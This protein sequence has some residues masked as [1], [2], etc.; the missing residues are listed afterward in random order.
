MVLH[1]Q[2]YKIA[3]MYFSVIWHNRL[4]VLVR[5][6]PVR[7]RA[8][9][10]AALG[11]VLCSYWECYL[12][13]HVLE[14]HKKFSWSSMAQ[15]L[16]ED[17]FYLRRPQRTCC[18]FC[19]GA[20]RVVGALNYGECQQELSAVLKSIGQPLP[21][22]EWLWFLPIQ[23]WDNKLQSAAPFTHTTQGSTL[24]ADN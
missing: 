11:A 18:N 6:W 19:V 15:L 23:T 3:A 16:P 8:K 13:I 10:R 7:V 4:Y 5:S 17:A 22:A 14:L 12:C 9:I 1:I 24:P 20:N 21:S 2:P